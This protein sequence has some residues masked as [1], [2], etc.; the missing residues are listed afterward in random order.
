M[1]YFWTIKNK[2][3]WEVYAQGDVRYPEDLEAIKNMDEFHNSAQKMHA[4]KQKG[5]AGK[6][7]GRSKSPGT[8]SSRDIT[9]VME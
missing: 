9:Q 3:P 6:K 8:R 5:G 2:A 4:G 1:W 7:H